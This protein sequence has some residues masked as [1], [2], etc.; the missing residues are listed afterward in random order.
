[1]STGKKFEFEPREVVIASSA[2]MNYKDVVRRQMN[3]EPIGSEVREVYER[4]LNAV[5]GLLD[6]VAGSGSV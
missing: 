6:K 4:R 1:M 3:K 2:L 5:Q